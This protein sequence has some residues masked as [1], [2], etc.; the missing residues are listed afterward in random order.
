MYT[1]EVIEYAKEHVGEG[2]VG[3][4]NHIASEIGSV[5]LRCIRSQMDPQ[6]LASILYHSFRRVRHYDWDMIA[7]TEIANATLNGYIISEINQGTRHLRG[8]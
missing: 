5:V 7:Q 3:I 6:K 2:L 4:P 8:I 1:D